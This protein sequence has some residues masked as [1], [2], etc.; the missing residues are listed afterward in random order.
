MLRCEIVKDLLPLYAEK[1]LSSYSTDEVKAHLEQC[2]ECSAAYTAMTEPTA[3]VQLRVDTAQE[4]SKY[5]KKQKRK[6]GWK[7]GVI[8]LIVYVLV[9]SLLVSLFFLFMWGSDPKTDTDVRNYTLYMGENAY[10]E[11]RAKWGMDETIFPAEITEDMQ[12]PEYKMVYYNPWDAQFLSYLTVTYSEEDY[13]A[14]CARLDAYESGDYAGVYGVTG[15]CG[16]KDPLAVYVDDYHGFVYAI[17]TPEQENS[18]T[19]VEIIFCNYFM[20]LEYEEYIPLSYLPDGFD[21]TSNNPY[22]KKMMKED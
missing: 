11:Y 15:F 5:Q 13:A 16:G 9:N 19:Y 1:M 21:A 7:V 12:V 22:E 4:F 20:D 8:C 2:T 18:I 10:E 3:D 6:L 17:P 14:E